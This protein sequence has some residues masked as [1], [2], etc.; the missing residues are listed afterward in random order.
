VIPLNLYEPPTANHDSRG[1]VL[2]PL[3]EGE[4]AGE[5]YEDDGETEAYRDN[6]HGAWRITMNSAADRISVAASASG[7]HVNQDGITLLLPR[8]EQR[9]VELKGAALLARWGKDVVSP[10]IVD[11]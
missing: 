2:F 6:N 8:T 4:S 7:K 5:S 1:F 11:Q 3:A 10:P 9:P